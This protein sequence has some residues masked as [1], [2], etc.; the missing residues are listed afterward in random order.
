MIG[1]FPLTWTIGATWNSLN[2]H[3]NLYKGLHCCSNG[4][5]CCRKLLCHVTDVWTLFYVFVLIITMHAYSESVDL[6]VAC[7]LN[8]VLLQWLKPSM[9]IDLLFLWND[10]NCYIFRIFCKKTPQFSRKKQSFLWVMR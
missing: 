5:L 10:F 3:F 6:L 7:L 4:L 1:T 2:I 8:L 9:K